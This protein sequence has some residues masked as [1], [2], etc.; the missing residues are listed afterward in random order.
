MTH[1]NPMLR[2][3]KEEWVDYLDEYIRL[4]KNGKKNFPVAALDQQ[5]VSLFDENG[6]FEA[7]ACWMRSWRAM[8]DVNWDDINYPNKY[9]YNNFSIWRAQACK[10]MSPG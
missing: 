3:L 2:R 1:N 6:D 8:R 5:L 10:P 4:L 9:M 7:V